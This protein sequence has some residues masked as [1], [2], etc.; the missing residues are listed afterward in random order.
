MAVRR[1]TFRGRSR[2]RRTTDWALGPIDRDGSLGSTGVA[3][4]SQGITVTAGKLTV[5]RIR[6]MAMVQLLT[7]D[8]VGSGMHGAVGI[9][10]ATSAAFAAGVASLP[11][12]LTEISWDGWIWHNIFDVRAITGTRADGVNSNGA[13]QLM[14]IDSKAMRKFDDSMTI[15]GIWETVESTNATIEM[16]ATTRVLTMQG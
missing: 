2:S 10:L 5:V 11:S 1:S 12:P 15:F 4:W 16:Q 14:E 13:R 7:A 8:A 3:L 6:G 9:G